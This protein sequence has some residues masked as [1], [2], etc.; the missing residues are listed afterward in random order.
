MLLYKCFEFVVNEWWESNEPRVGAF[1]QCG[2]N[3]L[4]M[5]FSICFQSVFNVLGG[6]KKSMTHVSA[7]KMLSEKGETI[8]IHVFCVVFDLKN[9]RR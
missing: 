2:F 8:R 3:V 1:A 6:I 4:C 5:R 7:K 9:V